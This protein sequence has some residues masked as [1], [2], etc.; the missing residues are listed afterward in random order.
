MFSAYTIGVTLQVIN[1][2]SAPLRLVT[3]QLGAAQTAAAALSRAMGSVGASFRNNR[4]MVAGGGVL[5]MMAGGAILRG[6]GDMALWSKEYHARLNQL[7][8]AG[9]TEVEVAASVAT[10]WKTTGEVVQKS[11][12]ENLHALL[13]LRTAHIDLK[14]AQRFLPTLQKGAVIME[15][16]GYGTKTREQAFDAAKF[17]D[18]VGAT[19]DPKMFESWFGRMMQ[20]SASTGNR[21]TPETFRMTAKWARQAATGYTE[22]FW[23]NDLVPFLVDV[24]NRSGGGSGQGGLG[25]P[26]AAFDKV[27]VQGIMKKQTKQKLDKYG[28]IQGDQKLARQKD[29]TFQLSGGMWNRALAQSNPALYMQAMIEKLQKSMN[30]GK[31][32]DADSL[33]NVLTDLFSGV[34]N[35]A[36]QALIN[37][38][39]QAWKIDRGTKMMDTTGSMGEMYAKAAQNPQLAQD[40]LGVQWENFKTVVS[41]DAM[42]FLITF[43][44]ESTNAISTAT[45]WM[46]ANPA[47]A[48]LLVKFLIGLGGALVV[49]GGIA[50]AGAGIMVI[51]GGLAA[52]GGALASPVFATGFLI[53][54]A[55]A[56]VGT[57]LYGLYNA[58]ASARSGIASASS[59][60]WQG[61]K[62]WGSSLLHYGDSHRLDA[63]GTRPSNLLLPPTGGGSSSNPEVHLF[64]DGGK[65]SKVMAKRTARGVNVARMSG[66]RSNLRRGAANPSTVRLH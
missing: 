34:P 46:V 23:F 50:V 19:K 28:L 10:A 6:V 13:D 66:A 49:L 15:A 11:A 20:V 41:K 60:M 27:F 16:A 12:T 43:L 5:S 53:A 42:P 58:S 25:A 26:L 65:I 1:H 18:M 31:K 62:N 52:I 38:G 36:K 7:R 51:A 33:K 37:F 59:S 63:P 47:A 32:F 61:F 30:G 24:L 14:D 3:G 4:L 64:L 45:Q 54:G 48:G 56:A 8:L 40:A 22:K 35:T 44:R 9:M 17:L 29:G 39:T 57:A 21:I 2:L 55:I